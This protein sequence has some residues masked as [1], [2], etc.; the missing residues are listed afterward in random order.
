MSGER[1]YK[2]DAWLM[3]RSIL[4]DLILNYVKRRYE[5][6]WTA[7]KFT[8]EEP[9]ITLRELEEKLKIPKPLILDLLKEL[10]MKSFLKVVYSHKLKA[11]IVKLKASIE[12]LEEAMQS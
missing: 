2:L 7:D 5:E 9:K 11:K 10:D 3:P 8:L 6:T 12:D 1:N 4:K